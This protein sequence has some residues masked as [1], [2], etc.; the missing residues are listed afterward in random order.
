MTPYSAGKYISAIVA[1]V[2]V[3]FGVGAGLRDQLGESP[4]AAA[5][6]PVV[7][8]ERDP[9][10]ESIAGSSADGAHV[11][12]LHWSSDNDLWYVRSSP[13]DEIS[14]V[15][16]ELESGESTTWK[17][18]FAEGQTP[19][20]Y[21]AED[22][23][24]LLWVGVGYSL[25]AFDPASGSFTSVI[26]LDPESAEAE[27]SALDRGNSLPG[28][29][30]AGLMPGAAGDLV[31]VRNNVLATYTVTPGGVVV[32]ERLTSAPDGLQL[33]AGAARPYRFDGD[34]VSFVDDAPGLEAPGSRVAAATA[35]CGAAA[36]VSAGT[37]QFAFGGRAVSVEGL[38]MEP[39]EPI[40]ANESFIAMGLSIDG[41]V[42][43]LDCTSGAV[44]RY[45]LGSDYVLVSGPGAS[46]DPTVT[47]AI[48][49]SNR[50]IEMRHHALAVAVSSAG[51]LAVGIDTGDV[52]I[53]R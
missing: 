7:P 18:P 34:E 39:R 17:A 37:A 9:A 25:A 2:A 30:I 36:D 1:V 46:S 5:T 53:I 48:E 8:T 33:V 24:G 12:A 35:S 13:G 32:A 11:Y 3:G 26:A 16:F 44:D 49:E 27:P 50:G 52:A 51:V 31:V 41:A 10:I 6:G 23:A 42:L 47:A 19:H 43:R 45:E 29:W 28:T 20:T 22:G 40:A 21:V 14:V 38:G 4:T 15:R